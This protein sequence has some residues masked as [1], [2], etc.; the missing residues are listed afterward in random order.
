MNVVIIAP[1]DDLPTSLALETGRH[2]PTRR[3][4]LS[5]RIAYDDGRFQ[6][7]KVRFSAQDIA[8]ITTL[9]SKPGSR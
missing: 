9:L 4:R 7:M 6:Q 8:S 2:H 5:M 3:T 1:R